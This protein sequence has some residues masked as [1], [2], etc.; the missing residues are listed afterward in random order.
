[1]NP[2]MIFTYLGFA[3]GPSEGDVD[4]ALDGSLLQLEK[5]E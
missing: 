1:M 3:L 2:Q 5:K 4:G